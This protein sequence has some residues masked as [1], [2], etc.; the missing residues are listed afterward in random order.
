MQ[1]M[2]TRRAGR[3]ARSWRGRISVAAAAGVLLLAP[4]I[5]AQEGDDMGTPCEE[6][7]YE[8]EQACY[9]GCN[10]DACEQACADATEDCLNACE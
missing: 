7:C 4:A 8:Q 10:D 1:P 5:A 6:A 9:D 2:R 3:G